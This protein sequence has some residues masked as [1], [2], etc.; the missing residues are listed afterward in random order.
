[1][2][3]QTKINFPCRKQ[4]SL[5]SK[6]Q[7]PRSHGL[8]ETHLLFEHSYAFRDNYNNYFFITFVLAFNALT[9]LLALLEII[10]MFLKKG[11]IWDGAIAF[12]ES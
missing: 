6:S 2:N 12:F 3:R 9:P 7:R 11:K 5:S 4:T 8:Y 10:V 1:M